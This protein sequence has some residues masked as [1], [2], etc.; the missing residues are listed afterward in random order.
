MN[1]LEEL[2]TSERQ[3][4]GEEQH[5]I[6]EKRR[7]HHSLS[8]SAS[9]R[10]QFMSRPRFNNKTK[11]GELI[12]GVV[13]CVPYRFIPG[14]KNNTFIMPDRVFEKGNAAK[15]CNYLSHTVFIKMK[16]TSVYSFREN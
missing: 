6:K 11:E 12:D 3:S 10:Q 15:R 4:I 2:V 7:M 1:L 16:D 14:Y 9:K 13:K 5:K 8:V